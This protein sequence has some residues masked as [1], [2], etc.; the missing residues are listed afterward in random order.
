LR[1]TKKN[2]ITSGTIF[3]VTKTKEQI[4][5]IEAEISENSFW[6][7]NTNAQETYT[8]LSRLKNKLEKY[9][10]VERLYEETEI[11][12]NIAE[13]DNSE[14]SEN[15]VKEYISKLTAQIDNMEIEALLSHKYDTYNC[16]LS[17]NS[18]AGGTDAQ[19]WTQILL[20]MYLRWLDKKQYKYQIVDENFGDEAGLKSATIIVNGL[21][22]F[23]Y[24]KNEIGIHR[25]VRLS[26]FNANNKRQTSFAAIDVIPELSKDFA[27]IDLDQKDLKID[28]FRASGAGGQHVNKTDSAVRITHIPTGLIAQ[29]QNSRSQGANK[30]T[31]LS[32]LK[33]RIL[34]QQEEQHKAQV[35]ELRSN[36]KEIAWGHQIRS[37]V[38]HPY[39]L[40]KDLRTGYERT[41]INNIMDGDLDD[42]INAN[43]KN[44]SKK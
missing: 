22:S 36:S 21:Y 25:L 31:A 1:F 2:S 39:K 28:T 26:P 27:N 32:I 11:I 41:D 16:I 24:L 13:E 20:R 6:E 29:S 33:S 10:R 5:K 35:N 37:Y 12:I 3:D 8:K 9:Q 40:I 7:E 17:I 30:E 23:G 19:D 34:Q 44:N 14:E 43:L 15:E 4:R 42:F 38:F 18:G